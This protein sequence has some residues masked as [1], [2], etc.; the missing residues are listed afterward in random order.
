MKQSKKIFLSLV[1]FMTLSLMTFKPTIKDTIKDEF[2]N[3]EIIETPE[4]N[5]SEEIFIPE[6]SEDKPQIINKTKIYIN[7]SVQHANLYINGKGSEASNMLDIAKYLKKELDKIEFLEVLYNFENLSL[8]NSIK[9][10]NKFNADIHLALHSNAGGGKGSE[11]FTLDS[12][13]FSK[14]VYEDFLKLGSF[15][16]RGIKNGAHLYEVKNSKADHVALME[17][18]FHDNIEEANWIVN[19][20]E[21]I[22]KQ[23]AQSIINFVSVYYYATR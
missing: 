10:S 17:F 19:N 11:I 23:L 18:L 7:P 21:K 2:V 9:E 4:N 5:S 3:S 12:Y 22:A 15:K 8:S 13:D 20:K 16:K 14:T 1:S 6:Y